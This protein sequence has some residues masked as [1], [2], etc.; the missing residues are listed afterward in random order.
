MKIIK[1]HQ[2]MDSMLV[3]STVAE[4]DYP[5][6]V[7][8]TTYAVGTRVIRP[9]VHKVYERLIA[10]AGT[11]APEIDTTSPANWLDVGPTKR[12]APF[13]N[14][15][16]TLASGSSP[17][18]YVLRTGFTD[19]LALFELSGRYVDVTMKD[20]AG[21]T[22]VYQ[23]RI[24]LEVTDIETI[25][26][27]FFTELDLRTD[28]VITDLPGQYASAE[29][30]ISLTATTGTVSVGVIKPGLISDLGETQAGASVGIDD[31]SRKERDE[32]GN[33]VI[34]ER[35]YSKKGSF[36]M[37]T[38]LGTFNRIYRTLAAL[39]ATPCVYIGTEELGY[40]PLLIYGFFTSFN[41]DITYPEYHLCSL[42]I[43][44]LI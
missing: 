22:V 40:E 13:D 4:N 23:N 33:T 10:G 32:F 1:P 27:W 5:V 35:A 28:V 9:T 26:D 41:I 2:M 19:S 3:S 34:L 25:F 17:L 18:T 15:V 39:R 6:W 12:W 14:V 38:T 29:L 24:D 37:L 16:G 11:V 8:G 7:S 44:G 31:Y 42:D 43:E 20:G 30:T 21:G 36:T